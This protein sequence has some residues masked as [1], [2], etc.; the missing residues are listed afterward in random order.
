MRALYL[1]F[2]F[3]LIQNGFGQD[4]IEDITDQEVLKL[5]KL[6]D[7]CTCSEIPEIDGT[8]I[9]LYIQCSEFDRIENVADLDKIAWPLNPNGL[10]ISATFDGLG[11]STLGKLPPN[12]QVETLRFT[13]NAIKAYWPDPFSDVPNL[14]VL[15]FSHNELAE[16]TPDLFTK[17]DLLE[18]LDLSYNKLSSFTKLDFKHLRHIKKLNLQSNNLKKIPLDALQPMKLLEDLDLSKNGIFDVVLQR[19]GLMNLARLKRLSLN[20]NRIRSIVKETFSLNNSLEFIDLSNNMIEIIEDTAFLSC[21]NLRELNL[22]QNNITFVF[23]LPPS[24]QIAILKFNTLYHWP[25]FPDGIKYIDVSYNRLSALYD[26]GTTNFDSLEVLIMGGNQIKELNIEKKLPSLYILDTS[27]NLMAEIPKTI[28]TQNF[29]N[30]EEL[31]FDGNPIEMVYF[32]NIIAV[33]SLYMNDIKTLSVVEDKAFSNVVGR[34]DDAENTLNCFSLYLSNC[35]LLSKINSGAFD[36]TSL[37]MLDISHNNLTHLPRNLLDWS[38]ASEGVNLQYNPWNCSC[39]MQWVVRDL[40]PQ[41]Y[42]NRNSRLL[43][44]LRCGSP[45]AFEGLRLVHWYNWT[46]DA[47]CSDMFSRSGMHGN[48]M[49]ESSTENGPRVT[50]LTLILGGCIIVSLLIAIALSVYLVKTRKKYNIRQ[51]AM[52]RKRQSAADLNNGNK[53][54]FST[55][56]KV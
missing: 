55:L 49:L 54:Q 37:C 23:A 43:A 44:E 18:D 42:A 28:S 15:S 3:F 24:L 53:E 46:E 13:N 5:I 36:G 17:V 38:V 52:K 50:N 29:P 12:S 26:E 11:L 48:Y 39:D 40:L 4:V 8:H 21:T 22:A 16:I 27:Y 1:T 7:V 9:V 6:C 41:M 14:K 56:N 45:R 30:L 35:P 51:A 47:M 10:K 33:K 19:N 34:A 25:K 2:I 32:K 20:E 31:H